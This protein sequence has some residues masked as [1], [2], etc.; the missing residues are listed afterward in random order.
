MY[1]KK[2]K[3]YGEYIYHLSESIGTCANYIGKVYRGISVLSP[4]DLYKEGKIITWQQF[5]SASK[6]QSVAQT[7]LKTEGK[8]LIGSMFVIDSSKAKEIEDLSVYPEE[9]ETLFTCN[10]HFKVVKKITQ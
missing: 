10:S 3:A 4:D 1:D 6:K 8:K 9:K 5:S 7:F 2:L